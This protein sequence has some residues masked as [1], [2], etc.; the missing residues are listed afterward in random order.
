[1]TPDCF[2]AT[3]YM[4]TFKVVYNS[5]C[6]LIS[7]KSLKLSENGDLE[8]ML[9]DGVI[10]CYYCNDFWYEGAVGALYPVDGG[11]R[12]FRAAGRARSPA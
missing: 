8:A 12:H 9:G 11:R 5:M 7:I 3:S 2:M 1:M 10:L 4:Y 6:V